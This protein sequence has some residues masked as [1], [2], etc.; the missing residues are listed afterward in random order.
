MSRS[1]FGPHSASR[2]RQLAW[3]DHRN[4]CVGVS[5]HVDDIG[6]GALASG[7][8]ARERICRDSSFAADELPS[9][10][11]GTSFANRGFPR[12]LSPLG[13]LSSFPGS[14]RWSAQQAHRETADEHLTA[15]PWRSVIS[16]T[17]W[18]RL[19]NIGFSAGLMTCGFCLPFVHGN[20]IGV[21]LGGSVFVGSIVSA[22]ILTWQLRRH[23]SCPS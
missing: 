18:W 13:T 4:A 23:E 22:A 9:M 8:P 1:R 3:F 16:F 11:S 7:P 10:Q 5:D 15:C 19:S 2:M 20:G 12:R 17:E 14:R 6:L 21:L